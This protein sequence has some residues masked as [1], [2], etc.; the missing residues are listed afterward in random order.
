MEHEAHRGNLIEKLQGR[1]ESWYAALGMRASLRALPI[2]IFHYNNKNFA[3]NMFRGASI[4]WAHVNRPSLKVYNALIN[5]AQRLESDLLYPE[6]VRHTLDA[7]RIA[8]RHAFELSGEDVS[9]VVSNADMAMAIGSSANAYASFDCW[10]A[11]EQDLAW[12]IESGSTDA[13]ARALSR[14][15]LWLRKTRSG[16]AE[17]PP[18]DWRDQ[19]DYALSELL[20]RDSSF[21]IWGTWFDRRIDGA[22]P[23]FEIKGDRYLRENNRI[24]GQLVSA[25]NKY[26]WNNGPEFVNHSIQ[27][28]VSD[29]RVR[30][31]PSSP[32]TLP[33]QNPN[34]I[35]FRQDPNG[36]IAIDTSV[37]LNS[38]RTDPDA[39]DRHAELRRYAVA[40]LARCQGSNAGARL[41]GFLE[42]YIEALGD[43]NE[44]QRPSLLVQRGNRLD[45]EHSAYRD[46]ATL[47]S[48]LADDVLLDLGNL[49]SAHHM[50]VMSEPVLRDR[51]TAMLGPDTKPILIPPVEIREVAQDADD[52]GIL[53]PGVR[54]V[55]Q[56]AAELSPPLPDP[57]NRLTIWSTETIKNLIIEA[58]AMALN[59]PRKTAGLVV[60]VGMLPLS[61]NPF[62]ALDAAN[63]LIKNRAWIEAKLGNAPTWK[64]LFKDLCAWMDK[65][66]P[67]NLS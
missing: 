28:W 13:A 23:A 58:F 17:N 33:V 26:F 44:S 21:E 66:A 20:K 31:S 60:A 43:N 18:P 50:H 11:A 37:D 64:A 57:E 16:W 56:E 61:L 7:M 67:P 29:A 48:P 52:Q 10:Q 36:K 27:S 59:H 55:L 32:A 3:I 30:T 34:A 42:N 35:A 8:T 9:E 6:V 38:L 47:L 51:A 45:V 49:V 24:L 25:T 54:E 4:L 5:S 15:A 14:K 65:H 22:N 2:G 46:P 1:P 40:L 39:R 63:F 41:T 53:A 62:A 12:L 19:W